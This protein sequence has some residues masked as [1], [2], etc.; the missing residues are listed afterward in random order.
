LSIEIYRLTG[1]RYGIEHDNC[2]LLLFEL[3]AEKRRDEWPKT[4]AMGRIGVVAIVFW[5]ATAIMPAAARQDE[6]AVLLVELSRQGKYAEATPLAERALALIE[7]SAPTIPISTMLGNSANGPAE[8]SFG[9]WGTGHLP[10]EWLVLNLTV[11]RSES[12]Y[13]MR[14]MPRWAVF[15]AGMYAG[16]ALVTFG[17]QTYV[18]LDACSG[19]GACA[20][21]LAKGAVW[22]TIW[23]ASWPVYA[24][25][26]Q[27]RP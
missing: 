26:L 5:I 9:A 24:A 15:V 16:A 14:P 2:F 13:R 8:R 20:V 4:H 12:Q 11:A 19:Y 6:A 1:D 18:R 22:S 25:G 7:K 3:H 27:R 21:S 17:F 10:T 23:P